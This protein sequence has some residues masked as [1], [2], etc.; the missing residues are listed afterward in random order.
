MKHL[1]TLVSFI[2]LCTATAQGQDL[3]HNFINPSFVGGNW[4]NASWLL[5]QATAQNG[6][7]GPATDAYDYYGSDPLDDFAKSLNRQ[8]LN[9]ISRELLSD[10]FGEGGLKEGMYEIG[11]Y[12]IDV[13]E[14]L[15]GITINI[16]DNVNGGETNIVVP[17]F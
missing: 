11:D 13:K 17:Y 16:T 10:T 8:I 12:T 4:Y 7:K 9:Q 15:E 1:L 2:V 5:Q 14:T 6:F 3:V